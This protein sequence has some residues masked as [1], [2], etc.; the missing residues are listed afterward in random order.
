MRY[1]RMRKKRDKEI[2][3]DWKNEDRRRSRQDR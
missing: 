2:E 3:W 1:G